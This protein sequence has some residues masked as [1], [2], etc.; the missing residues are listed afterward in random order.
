MN[1]NK[2]NIILNKI[3]KIN[4]LTN[5]IFSDEIKDIEDMYN[6]NIF[7]VVVIGEFSSGKS[8]F[9]NALIGRRILYSDIDEA[10]GMTTTIENSDNN[11][12]I[13]NFEDGDIKK[14][15][16]ILIMDMRNYQNI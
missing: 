12:A 3:N 5:K 15:Q 9:L 14:Y 13:I 16:L 11:V 8:T 4:H 10:T 7:K 2:I 6:D 1:E